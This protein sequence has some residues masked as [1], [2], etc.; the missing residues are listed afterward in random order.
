MRPLKL[1]QYSVTH[2]YC[3]D[4]ETMYVKT[5]T[6]YMFYRREHVVDMRDGKQDEMQMKDHIVGMNEKQLPVHGPSVNMYQ[7]NYIQIRRRRHKRR[8]G[9][10]TVPSVAQTA[11]SHHSKLSVEEYH[12]R[13]CVQSPYLNHAW[14]YAGYERYKPEAPQVTNENEL[15]KKCLTLLRSRMGRPTFTSKMRERRENERNERRGGGSKNGGES[16]GRFHS[17]RGS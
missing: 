6:P 15:T 13:Y 7:P 5:E 4:T 10:K 11:S 12:R 8:N 9:R 17:H 1:L 16:R 14:V 3:P 2:W